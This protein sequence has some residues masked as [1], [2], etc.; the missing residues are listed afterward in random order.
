MQPSSSDAGQ[1]QQ[2]VEVRGWIRTVRQ[3]K[4]FAFMQVRAGLH[5]L[6]LWNSLQYV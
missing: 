5:Q 1:E 6:T 4:Q 2:K 3:Q